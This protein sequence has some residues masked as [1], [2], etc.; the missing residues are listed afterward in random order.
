MSLEGQ[1]KDFELTCVCVRIFFVLNVLPLEGAL[2]FFKSLH[3]AYSH[4]MFN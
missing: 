3:A 4:P 2:A 1:D